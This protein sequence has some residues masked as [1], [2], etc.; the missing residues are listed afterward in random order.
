V[1]PEI[2][3]TVQTYE[4]V[5]DQV[6]LFARTVTKLFSGA[7]AFAILMAITGIYAMGSNAVVLRTQEIGLRRAL[8]ATNSRVF[9]LFVAQSA[10]QLITGL[11]FSAA[12]SIAAL[13]AIHRAFPVGTGVLALIGSGV[14][15]VVSATVLLSIYVAV[16]GALRLEPSSALHRG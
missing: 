15:L 8:G 2:A 14:V 7:G 5:L 16:R 9:A 6:T 12:L 13:V 10:R 3:P 11:A 4:S 1:D